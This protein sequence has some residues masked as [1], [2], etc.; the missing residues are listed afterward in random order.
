MN[1]RS[2][3]HQRFFSSNLPNNHIQQNKNY[4]NNQNEEI[5]QIS[6]ET[7]LLKGV[8]SNLNILLS[9]L[10]KN[11]QTPRIYYPLNSKIKSPMKINQTNNYTEFNLVDTY[12]NILE[13]N[14]PKS[15]DYLSE[16]NSS[17]KNNFSDYSYPY[18]YNNRIIID[19]RN[20]LKQNNN[21]NSNR[22]VNLSYSGHPIN[23]INNM[24]QNFGVNKNR[25]IHKSN[26]HQRNM[27]Q[28]EKNKTYNNNINRFLK[29]KNNQL[30]QNNI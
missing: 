5:K 11:D 19:N 27:N 9:N 12:N 30:N 22:K 14:I 13:S 8:D 25:I 24:N 21:N 6:Y 18:S 1:H 16:N 3:S 28:I 20:N 7:N 15:N 10:K 17:Y 4:N 23:N 29:N 26:N 2:N